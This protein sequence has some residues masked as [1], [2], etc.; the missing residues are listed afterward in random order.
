M[1]FVSGV[2]FLFHL[3]PQQK[4]LGGYYFT[5]ELKDLSELPHALHLVISIYP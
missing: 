4:M 1:R 2:T 5:F 3:A